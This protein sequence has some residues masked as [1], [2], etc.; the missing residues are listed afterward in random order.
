MISGKIQNIFSANDINQTVNT[1]GLLNSLNQASRNVSTASEALAR[2]GKDEA[3]AVGEV[4]NKE[5][6]ATKDK[7]SSMSNALKSYD[8]NI[9]NINTS[10]YNKVDK[11]VSDNIDRI[12]QENKGILQALTP[13]IQLA[14]KKAMLELTNESNMQNMEDMLQFYKDNDIPFN[15]KFGGKSFSS[16]GS[17]S[18]NVR[19]VKTAQSLTNSFL[20]ASADNKKL[21]SSLS[22][23]EET[24]SK[25]H[26]GKRL[27]F[28]DDSGNVTPKALQLLDQLGISPT[29]HIN[30]DTG[31]KIISYDMK[32]V[33]SLLPKL[34]DSLN[35]PKGSHIKIGNDSTLGIKNYNYNSGGLSLQDMIAA[36]KVNYNDLIVMSKDPNFKKH[37]TSPDKFKLAEGEKQLIDAFKY[38]GI[39][40][41]IA[42]DLIDKTV[43]VR[44]GMFNGVRTIKD[45]D[46]NIYWDT[47]GTNIW[48][49]VNNNSGA[50]H[51]SLLLAAI[52]VV[53]SNVDK[54]PN[55]D[56]NEIKHKT[57]EQFTNVQGPI[58]KSL[59]SDAPIFGNFGFGKDTANNI[60]T[61]SNIFFK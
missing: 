39:P 7:Y 8:T 15:S 37:Y 29:Q 46:S 34:V 43:A 44:D 35:L 61:I 53:N 31:E 9:N 16:G 1:A 54:L 10:F 57:Y 13:G 5:A 30:P 21:R 18:T 48:D 41:N 12:N 58:Y 33:D 3:R 24:Y 49:E 17:N 20:G 60:S 25:L 23:I 47:K 56:T 59:T 40:V 38:K 42:K 4:F 2:T 50:S 6:T 51:N 28:I 27:G 32:I 14:T 55:I 52:N 45:V 36:K 22:N 26:N 11:N 19:S